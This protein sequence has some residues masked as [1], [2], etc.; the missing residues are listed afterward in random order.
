MNRQKRLT[1]VALLSLATGVFSSPTLPSE[2]NGSVGGYV[3]LGEAGVQSVVYLEGDG[4]ATVGNDTI[5]IDQIERIYTPHLTTI[6]K[7]T[8]IEFLNSDP[9]LHNVYCFSDN[10]GAG[11]F[12]YAMPHFVR[13][14]KFYTFEEPGIYVLLCNVHPKMEAFIVVTPTPYAATTDLETGEYRIDGIPPGRYRAHVWKERMS[15]EI[16]DVA[17]KD[18]EVESGR[19]SRLNFQPIESVAGD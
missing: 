18:L 5:L 11:I 19:H 13:R 15:R 4:L 6:P 17:T 2:A 8:A 9:F 1:T 3:G 14:G 10:V 16:L 12:N 7:G